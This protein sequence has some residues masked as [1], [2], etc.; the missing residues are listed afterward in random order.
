MLPLLPLAWP[1]KLKNK[2]QMVAF[3]MSLLNRLRPFDTL[4]PPSK[5][6]NA[7]QHLAGLTLWSWTSPDRVGSLTVSFWTFQTM[8]RSRGVP[9]KLLA[10]P[11]MI[12]YNSYIIWT[13]VQNGA[14][15]K[16]CRGLALEVTGFLQPDLGERSRKNCLVITSHPKNIS[17]SFTPSR[18]SSFLFRVHAAHERFLCRISST[19]VKRRSCEN[20]HE[21]NQTQKALMQSWIP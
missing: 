16:A 9:T 20:S 15:T 4:G 7:R 21:R 8:R 12:T 1:N 14:K 13:R 2:R 5:E 6:C 18:K 3:K 19:A 10:F 17:W 11:F